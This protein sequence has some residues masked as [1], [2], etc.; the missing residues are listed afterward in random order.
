MPRA[1][2]RS[3][4]TLVELLIVIGI[5]ALLVGLAIPAVQSMRT[6]AHRN[7]CRNNLRNLALATQQFEKKQSCYPGYVNEL[8]PTNATAFTWRSWTFMLLPFLERSDIYDVSVVPGSPQPKNEVDVV[9]CP[10]QEPAINLS[11][12]MTGYVCNTGLPDFAIQPGS[13]FP[14]D[15]AANGVFH[16]RRL[17]FSL[18]DVGDAAK[19]V[20]I[21]RMTD[22]YISTGDGTSNTILLT[23]NVNA[24]SWVLVGDGTGGPINPRYERQVGCTW[25]DTIQGGLLKPPAECRINKDAGGDPTY[26]K[27]NYARP[28]SPHPGLVNVAF[29]DGHVRT[30]AQQIDYRVYCL[31]MAPRDKSTCK[32][33]GA[34]PVTPEDDLFRKAVMDESKIY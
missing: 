27:P 18:A 5:I 15:Y 2:H 22:G 6:P 24:L 1:N 25:N 10:S 29:C 21:T 11:W 34:Y 7:T 4:Y 14:A 31:L 30:I 23:E 19:C 20:P 3:A 17:Y 28:S 13:P 33:D 16:D 9:R 26:I 32:T 12:P 8:Y